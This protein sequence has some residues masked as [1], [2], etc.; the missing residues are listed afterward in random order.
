MRRALALINQLAAEFGATVVPGHDA[1]TRQRF[2]A[3]PG[4]A[5]R[6]AVVL[7]D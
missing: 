6:V 4:P 3:L 5:G 7:A 1:R 2:P